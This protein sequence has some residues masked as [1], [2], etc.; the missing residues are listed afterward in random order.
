MADGAIATIDLS[1]CSLVKYEERS[2]IPGIR[3]VVKNCEGWTP[4]VKVSEKESTAY[5][6][7]G[8]R[9]NPVRSINEILQ[10]D[11]AKEVKYVQRS[12]L[13]GVW[14]CLPL[15]SPRFMRQF[16]P[17]IM[18]VTIHRAS[19]VQLNVSCIQSGQAL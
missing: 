13:H 2:H 1:T 19:A 6:G 16:T 11:Y 3:F 12:W 17:Y 8:S 18:R 9:R 5:N 7:D 4:V 10:L 15:F 14:L